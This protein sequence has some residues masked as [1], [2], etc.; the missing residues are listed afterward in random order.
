MVLSE[1]PGEAGFLTTQF[2]LPSLM[3]ANT[4]VSAIQQPCTP[5]QLAARACSRATMIGNGTATTPLLREPLG[6]SF[7]LVKQ[8]GQLSPVAVVL[9]ATE[10]S[11]VFKG[12]TAL[13]GTR[14]S[15]AISSGILDVPHG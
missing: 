14:V 11:L 4:T 13:Q 6:A 10:I 8:P 5:E 15:T 7:Y 1:R 12:T 2:V 9:R 3:S